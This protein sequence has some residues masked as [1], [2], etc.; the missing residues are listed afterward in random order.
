[1]MNNNEKVLTVD[2]LKTYF[3]TP[4]GIVKA[5]DDISFHVDKKEILAIVGESGCGKSITV[6]SIMG[7]V[8][9]PP[10]KMS[11]KIIFKDK[12]L[13][14]LPQK[15]F[16]NIRGKQIG[17]IFQ[18][19]MSAFDP[20]YTIGYQ[21]MEIVKTHITKNEEEGKKIVID[22]L[23]KVNIPEPEKRFSEYPHEMSGGMLQRILIAMA[24]VTNP[25]IIIADEPTTA[26]D[27]TI[28][29]QVINLMRELQRDFSSS[30]I[31]ITHDLGVVAE[32]A[33]R[34]HVMY[35]GK[36]V[37]KGN[38]VDIYEDPL[39]PYTKGLLISRVKKEYKGNDLPYI[40][41]YVP[42]AHEFPEG[43]RFNPR[44]PHA[45]EKCIKKIPP[46]FVIKENRT[47]SCWLYEG[48]EN[49]EN[50]NG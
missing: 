25:E 31:F 12:Q 15:E 28:Q 46:E 26:L 43:C 39:H 9:C 50:N 2:N 14:G 38:A 18:E 36:I 19:P 20:L 5:V 3:R 27:V 40:K 8:K 44:C 37:E 7:L 35:A 1:M 6:N 47:V 11:G 30:I 33:D 49:N 45:T 29:A 48:V 24:L 16:M 23:K 32:I 4:D 17:M 42:R 34:I 41:G 22:S 10:A 13:V 21:M